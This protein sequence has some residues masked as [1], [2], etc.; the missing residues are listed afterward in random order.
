MAL[1]VDPSVLTK[2]ARAAAK[3]TAE[4]MSATHGQYWAGRVDI[5]KLVL[6]LSSAIVV[7]SAA[8]ANKIVETAAAPIVSWV[9]VGSWLFFF[10]SISCC[11]ASLWHANTLNSFRARFSSSEL[12][13]KKEAGE[14]KADEQ[15]ALIQSVLSLVKKYSDQALLPLESADIL[16][17]KFARAS[18]FFYGLGLGSFI[19]VGGLLVA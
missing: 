12:E 17:D 4:E 7:G 19:V 9:L 5:A 3:A 16:S 6:S 8:F 2:R 15:E 11:L 18:M 10:L 14:L 1:K 13:M